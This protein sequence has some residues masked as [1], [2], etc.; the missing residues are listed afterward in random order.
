MWQCCLFPVPCSL[1]SLYTSDNMGMQDVGS[2]LLSS[3]EASC[4]RLCRYTGEDGFELS[5]PKEGTQDLADALLSNTD[6]RFAGLG[7]RDS[8]RL[9]AGLCL[10]GAFDTSYSQ[11]G[12]CRIRTFHLCRRLKSTYQL[13]TA[14]NT[15]SFDLDECTV[16]NWALI[17]C[18]SIPHPEAGSNGST[19]LSSCTTALCTDAGHWS[20]AA[21]RIGC[22]SMVAFCVSLCI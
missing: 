4:I 11:F 20:Y 5:I 2:T 7:A 15:A 18:V 14:L 21:C 6:C 3:L 10:Y 12:G 17:T 13:N 19:F 8:L 22:C 16:R 9:E 1:H